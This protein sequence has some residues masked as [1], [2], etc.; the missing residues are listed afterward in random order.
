MN[1]ALQ[2][3]M[4]LTRIFPPNSNIAFGDNYWR[5]AY[6]IVQFDIA[7][8]RTKTLAEK[9]NKDIWRDK[10]VD[11][12]QVEEVCEK[13]ERAGLLV[14][15]NQD[16]FTLTEDGRDAI[17]EFFADI[18]TASRAGRSGLSKFL[19]QNER[20]KIGWFCTYRGDR[21]SAKDASRVTGIAV[22]K[23]KQLLDKLTRRSGFG[24][25]PDRQ[26]K[27]LERTGSD[28]YN[29]INS[30]K[31][32]ES[33]LRD[34]YTQYKSRKESVKSM[35]LGVM[36][37]H[38]KIS[39]SEIIAHLKEAGL[40]FESSTIYHHLK[41]MQRANQVLF[42]GKGNKG[43]EYYKLNFDELLLYDEPSN[44][45]YPLLDK[46]N[47]QARGEFYEK[48][49]K[50]DPAFKNLFLDELQRIYLWDEHE[51]EAFPIWESFLKNVDQNRLKKFRVE[52]SNA[53][54]AISLESLKKLSLQFKISPFVIWLLVALFPIAS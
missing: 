18:S 49:K 19:S 21:V 25:A 53:H 41:E 33:L 5:I 26:E 47:L 4:N 20:G 23:C 52:L 31:L 28:T 3:L 43:M 12:K 17:A 8:F 42:A 32:F 30:E 16:V 54:S 45:I 11:L 48:F 40:S 35:M 34:Y 29:V 10:P 46:M 15:S 7:P 36:R 24:E 22:A 37:Y 27:L 9:I 13:F 2:Q 51:I 1:P 50:V 44:E 14:R 38:A 39:G 6:S